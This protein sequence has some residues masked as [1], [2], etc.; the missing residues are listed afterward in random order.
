MK[1]IASYALL[2]TACL[3]VGSSTSATVIAVQSASELTTAFQEAQSGDVIQL[4]TDIALTSTL[5]LGTANMTDNSRAL[6]LDLNGHTLSR[7]ANVRMIDVTHGSLI[8]QSS[9]AGGRVDDYAS[10]TQQSQLK[11]MML[12][13]G[14]YLK[15]INP[16]TDT[17]YYS[18]L[19]IAE[20]VTINAGQNAITIDRVGNADGH[21][22]QYGTDVYNRGTVNNNIG[23]A[24]G[25][26]VD[27]YGTIYANKYGIKPNGLLVAPTTDGETLR[28]VSSD[29]QY[30]NYQVEA[31][32]TA[33]APFIHVHPSALISTHATASEATAVYASGYARWLI[34]GGCYGNMG[35]YIRSGCVSVHNAYIESS[36][37]EHSSGTT[38]YHGV[39][40]EGS[41]IVLNARSSVGG[42]ISLYMSGATRVVSIAGYA[43]EEIPTSVE[44]EGSYIREI[45]LE[46]GTLEA[47][48]YPILVSEETNIEI[49]DDVNLAITESG[50]CGDSLTWSYSPTRRTLTITGSGT[51]NNYS[52]DKP[53]AEYLQEI[54][55]VE[56]EEGVTT[57]C[58]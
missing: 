2:L 16:R 24:H 38:Q 22:I 51:M 9:S 4:Q 39:E 41:A 45:L 29:S 42:D 19:V 35:L 27:I 56:I 13:T 3:A 34:E 49:G 20:G 31:T 33:Y 28:T 26:R 44:D 21:S 43:I 50:S 40:A 18:H 12:V 58:N 11:D 53:W 5:W 32:D 8:V 47:P 14:S 23:V 10:V 17:G 46:S 54:L 6:T 52:S 36:N 1:K 57:I 30:A 25:A 15:D 55:N 7:T 48:E 37:P